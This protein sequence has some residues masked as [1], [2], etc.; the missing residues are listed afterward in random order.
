MKIDKSTEYLHPLLV[1]V[2]ARIEKQVIKKYNAPFALFET[3]RSHD[4]H[5]MLLQRGKTRDLVSMHLYN[6]ENDPPLYATAIDY[7]YYDGKWS[8]NLR[9]ST[10][11]SWYYLFG[12]LVLDV[13]PEL[14]WAG[15][16]R[17]ATNLNHFELRQSVILDNMETIPCVIK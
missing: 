12:N 13:C 6:L 11:S 9:D 14:E 5:Q 10:V 17:K 1:S 2:I 16:N 4:R 8:W 3:G 15:L 7:V